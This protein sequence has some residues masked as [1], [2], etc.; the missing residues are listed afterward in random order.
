[1]VL[2]NEIRFYYGAANVAPLDGV[3]SELGQ[4]SGV[5]MASIPLDRFAGLRPRGQSEPPNP[6]GPLENIGQVTLK[7]LDLQGCTTITVNADCGEG[8]LRV[9]LL[10]EEGYR[11]RGYSKDESTVIQGN[12]LHH[13][14]AWKDRG[15][16][17]LP[18]DRYMLRFHIQGGTLF[19]VSFK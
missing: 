18:A 14:V 16:N 17:Q 15:L 3:K 5:G 10:T 12:S 13:K 1:V 4:R 6:A 19:A 2:E 8:S 9:E 7:P 11:V